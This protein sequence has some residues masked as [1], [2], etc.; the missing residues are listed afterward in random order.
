MR[1]LQIQLQPELCA[2]DAEPIVDE[3]ISI[4]NDAVS[5]AVAVVERGDDDGPYININVQTCDVPTL[6]TSVS[7]RISSNP[8]LASG[9]IVCCEGKN[10]WDDYLLLHH[11]DRSEPLDMLS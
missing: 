1:Y 4:A 8:S 5:D 7:A 9:M 3:L 11:Y 2:C 6:W 10:G